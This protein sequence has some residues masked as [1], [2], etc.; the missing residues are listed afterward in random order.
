M[1]PE[2]AD[3]WSC[4]KLCELLVPK[5]A[6]LIS[7]ALK[8]GWL[9]YFIFDTGL[10]LGTTYMGSRLGQQSPYSFILKVKSFLSECWGEGLP[11]FLSNSRFRAKLSE[12]LQRKL[13]GFLKGSGCCSKDQTKGLSLAGDRPLLIHAQGWKQQW[14]LS[15]SALG[16]S[17]NDPAASSMP[18]LGCCS[19][20]FVVDLHRRGVPFSAHSQPCLHPCCHGK[21]LPNEAITIYR[22]R[23]LL[24]PVLTPADTSECGMNTVS[25]FLNEVAQIG[26]SL[27]IQG[28][29][30]LEDCNFF[31]CGIH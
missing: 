11:S 12:E 9:C 20:S 24:S 18:S 17:W 10:K 8:A 27:L 5:E 1:W 29:L 14:S 22:N 30:C 2:I 28:D 15:V 4:A 26:A 25:S 23:I 31:S 21:L 16:A 6:K 3:F 13:C 19:C 7:W